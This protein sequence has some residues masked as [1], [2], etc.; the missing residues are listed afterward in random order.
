MSDMDLTQVDVAMDERYKL[1]PAKAQFH[2]IGNTAKWFRPKGEVFT[3]TRFNFKA[4]TQPMSNVRTSDFATAADIDHEF[5][6]GQQ[7]AYTALSYDRADM[8]MFE[9]TLE[10]NEL[11]AT[12]T[13]DQ[14]HAVYDLVTKMFRESDLE[15]GRKFNLAVHQD[16]ACAMGTVA[17][18]YASSGGAYSSARY[19]YIQITDVQIS[20][21]ARGEYLDIGGESDV[22]VMDV[23]EG[24]DGPWSGGTRI[25]DIG[26]GLVLDYGSGNTAD[27]TAADTITASNETTGDGM[28]GFDAW[29]SGTTNVYNDADGSAIDRDAAGNSW[30][31]PV[32]ET[33]AASGSETELDLDEHLGLLA[34]VWPQAVAWGRQA[35]SAETPEDNILLP[36]TLV[37]ITTAKLC[38]SVATEAEDTS[39]FTRTINMSEAKQKDLYGDVGFDGVMYHSAT[40]PPISF[41]ADDAAPKYKIRFIDPQSWGYL[42]LNEGGGMYGIQWLKSGGAGGTRWMRVLGTNNRPTHR[43]TAAAWSCALMYCDQ[44]KAN[45]EIRGVKS[46]R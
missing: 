34:D 12:V 9:G 21:F 16:T 35:R 18:I 22:L 46:H 43:L 27:S 24:S 36:S 32:I 45:A 19:A 20:K 23:I 42:T 6:A 17:A 30:G 11:A 10:I 5:P 14:K 31:I 2:R 39:R 38:N 8:T 40:L 3:G 37:G 44:P 41:Q 25:A 4:F 1:H 26:P 15:F 13:K 28:A 29:F 7:L 33:I